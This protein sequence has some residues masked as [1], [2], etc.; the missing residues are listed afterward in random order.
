MGNAPF[1]VELH[2]DNDLEVDLFL[3]E[4]L[5]NVLHPDIRLR[6]DPCGFALRCPI[7][8]CLCDCRRFPRSG[9]TLAAITSQVSVNS[10]HLKTLRQKKTRNIPCAITRGSS[11]ETI[12]SATRLWDGFNSSN[13]GT[14][15]PDRL[16]TFTRL[17]PDCAFF[18]LSVP[19]PP[20]LNHIM[21][22]N[23]DA[24]RLIR[25]CSIRW[26]KSSRASSAHVNSSRPTT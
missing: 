20:P 22:T 9:W 2:R 16:A 10:K 25:P 8:Q 7:L 18:V 19:F 11:S 6:D 3:E 21:F 15:T 4:A 26:I 12:A 23:G 5:G 14:P 13:V 17:S 24:C 1:K